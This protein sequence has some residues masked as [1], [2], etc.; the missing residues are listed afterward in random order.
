MAREQTNPKDENWQYYY[1]LAKHTTRTLH[2]FTWTCPDCKTVNVT[3]VNTADA[4]SRLSCYRGVKARCGKCH[5]NVRRLTDSS[6]LIYHP[7][8]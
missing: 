8:S 2:V 4:R 6:G 1:A 5:G 3:S 7:T